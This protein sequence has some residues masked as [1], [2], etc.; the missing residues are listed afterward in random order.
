MLS[1]TTT[2]FCSCSRLLVSPNSG[3]QSRSLPS[4]VFVTDSRR[5]RKRRK[6]VQAHTQ[7][8]SSSF[9]A[10]KES[11]GGGFLGF[12][13]PP[14]FVRRCVKWDSEE[15]DL[16]LEGEILEFMK[17]SKNPEAFPSK[18]ELVEAGRMDLVDAIAK[19]GGWLLLGW[20]L[21]EEEDEVEQRKV[22]E[23]VTACVSDS[24][25]NGIRSSEPVSWSSVNHSQSA[26]SSGRSLEM[27]AGDESGIEGILNR[28]ERQRN[29]SFGFDLRSKGNG[30]SFPR[31]HA[32]DDRHLGTSIDATVAGLESSKRASLSS[33]KR[34]YNDSGGKLDQNRSYLD[35]DGLRNSMKPDTW[36]TWSN[37]RAGFSAANFEAAEIGFNATPMDGSRDETLELGGLASDPLNTRKEPISCHEIN[38]NEIQTRLQHLELELTSVLHSVRSNAGQ[39]MSQKGHESSSEELQKL[40]DALE[41]QENEIM[42]AQDR[43]RSIRAKLTILE[44]KMALAI[45]DAQKVVEEKQERIDDARRAL[46]LLHTT[47]IVW[48]NSASEVLL[49]G[50]FDGWATQRK[51]EKSSTGIFSL[52]LKLYPGRYEIKFIVDGQWKVDPLRPIVK[53]NGYENNLLI[54]T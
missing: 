15:G 52:N 41:F 50:S 47:C 27:A 45:I 32:K 17:E 39:I 19:K 53:N 21:S 16:A 1:L 36:R 43:L 3:P 9:V 13:K 34:N 31:I 30:T 46:Q 5:R 23:N 38:V 28:L 49:A 12:Q 7:L 25:S 51:M 44:G 54:I 33:N 10:A 2:T 20:D 4:V 29:L 26:S 37:Q 14:G 18:K 42:D 24:D 48:P 8:V 40:S 35:D 6:T 22:Q 11:C